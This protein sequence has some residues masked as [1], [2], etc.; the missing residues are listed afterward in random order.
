L[1]PLVQHQKYKKDVAMGIFPQGK[2]PK[3]KVT[4]QQSAHR[5]MSLLKMDM[6]AMLDE[7]TERVDIPYNPIQPLG[8]SINCTINA[9]RHFMGKSN[10]IGTLINLYYLGELLNTTIKPQHTWKNYLKENTVPNPTRYYKGAM[11]TYEI[12]SSDKDQIYRTKFLS[13]HYIVGMTNEDYNNDFLPSVRNLVY[14]SED[15]AF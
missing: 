10:R 12:F 1:T 2:M 15:F 9:L 11:R 6:L 8:K 3:Q 5:K 14:A 7:T 4:R 13:M